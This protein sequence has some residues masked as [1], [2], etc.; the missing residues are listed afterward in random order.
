[1]VEARNG[2]PAQI[3]DLMARVAAAEQSRV[4]AAASDPPA[5]STG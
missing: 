4:A 2:V 1:M 3:G 5:P